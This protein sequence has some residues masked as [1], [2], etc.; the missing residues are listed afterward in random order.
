MSYRFESSLSFQAL[1]STYTCQANGAGPVSGIA[2]STCHAGTVVTAFETAGQ[3][4]VAGLQAGSL[5]ALVHFRE[6]EA[7]H[8]AWR[9]HLV[10]APTPCGVGVIPQEAL[11]W[12]VVRLPTLRVHELLPWWHHTARL[13][14]RHLC[15]AHVSQGRGEAT[16]FRDPWL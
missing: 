7:A 8:A 16:G 14:F 11:W 4:R 2:P 1:D 5:A 15:K 13:A 9:R 6:V 3:L 12:L 10:A